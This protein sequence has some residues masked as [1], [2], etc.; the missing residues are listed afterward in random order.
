[1]INNQKSQGRLINILIQMIHKV[2]LHLMS[3]IID[4]CRKFNYCLNKTKLNNRKK[5]K[6]NKNNNLANFKIQTHK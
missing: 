1:M 2:S 6:V 5:Q 3:K 4:K